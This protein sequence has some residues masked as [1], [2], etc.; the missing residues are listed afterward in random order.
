MGNAAFWQTISF[1]CLFKTAFQPEEVY[2]FLHR[3]RHYSLQKMSF[4]FCEVVFQNQCVVLDA[5]LL[6]C[7][8]NYL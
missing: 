1:I 8:S 4:T 6:I 5:G 7:A 3:I 2:L